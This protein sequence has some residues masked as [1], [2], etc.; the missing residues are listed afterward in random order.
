MSWLISRSGTRALLAADRAR[1]SSVSLKSTPVTSV[2]AG[3]RQTLEELARL[4]KE[5]RLDTREL[6]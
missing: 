1:S 3:V 5:G 4:A 2:E 6:A